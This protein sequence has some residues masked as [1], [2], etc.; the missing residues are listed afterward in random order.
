MSDT[1]WQLRKLLPTQFSVNL[2]GPLSFLNAFPF[3]QKVIKAPT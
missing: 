3:F 2:S 1:L